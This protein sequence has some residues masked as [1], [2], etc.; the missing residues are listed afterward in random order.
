ML[1]EDGVES[2]D[3]D[4]SLRGGH[5][6][7]LLLAERRQEPFSHR[8]HIYLVCSMCWRP[9]SPRHSPRWCIASDPDHRSNARAQ[10]YESG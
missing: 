1:S 4:A 2:M 10:Q 9:T 5:M 7:F 6:V 3:R 8:G